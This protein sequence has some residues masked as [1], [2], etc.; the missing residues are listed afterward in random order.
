MGGRIFPQVETENLLN[1]LDWQI[2]ELN[3]IAFAFFHARLRTFC[4]ICISNEGVGYQDPLL[5]V[6]SEETLREQ[7]Q[8]AGEQKG[9]LG[10]ETQSRSEMHIEGREEQSRFILLILSDV[11]GC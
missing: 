9:C 5:A 1:T 4:I 6:I 7:E 2:S 8:T 10:L 3:D 11:F